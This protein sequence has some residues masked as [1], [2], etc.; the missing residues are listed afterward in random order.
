MCPYKQYSYSEK[1]MSKDLYLLNHFD[2]PN[3]AQYN[4]SSQEHPAGVSSTLNRMKMRQIQPILGTSLRSS[5]PIQCP[6][7]NYHDDEDFAHNYQ[8]DVNYYNSLTWAMYNRI[9][10]AREKQKDCH[11]MKTKCF[12][13]SDPCHLERKR[14]GKCRQDN[15]S[16]N[17]TC[18]TQEED[19]FPIEL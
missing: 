5:E 9:T 18:C 3:N 16:K 13:V 15:D 1:A 14:R 2:C 7:S 17:C 12:G 8:R 11:A 4:Y 19:I 10:K 6:K